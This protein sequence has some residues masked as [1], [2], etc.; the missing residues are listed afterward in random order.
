M[1]VI[2]RIKQG[3]V[4]SV[5]IEPPVLG[6]SIQRVYDVLDPLV[7]LGIAYVDITYHPEEVVGFVERGDQ[8][9]PLHRR[10]KP[11][12]VGVAGAL[13]GRYQ[14][15]GIEPV[16]HVI[17]TGFN[18][19]ETE[20][21]LIELS[22]LG[23]QNVLALRGDPARGPDGKFVPFAAVPG[24]HE[25]AGSLVRQIAD[26]RSSTYVGAETGMPVDFCIGAACYPEKHSLAQSLQADINAL[27]EKVEQ[28]VDYLV[29]QMFFDVDM[30]SRF[31]EKTAAVGIAVPIVPALF[32]F[33]SYKYVTSLPSFFGCSIPAELA[34]R[35]EQYKK[36][37]E[38]MRKLGIE[39]CVQ[40]CEA[41]RKCGAPSLHFYLH[42]NAPVAEVIKLIR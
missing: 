42:R 18:R 24:G 17:C 40:Q 10:K 25:R 1:K 20:E 13:V 9:F 28:G 38:E 26:L 27:K 37:S 5:E 12:T 23:V 11:G 22:Y 31:V 35:A 34:S 29:T 32:P 2:D 30:Y 16:P 14:K 39:W 7:E 19:H 36:K 15:Q 21:Y 33:T 3:N 4:I 8:R 41:L 6:E